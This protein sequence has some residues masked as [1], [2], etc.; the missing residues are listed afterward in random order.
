MTTTVIS[1]GSHIPGLIIGEGEI[2]DVLYGGEADYPTVSSGGTV[3]LGTGAVVSRAT[4]ESGGLVSGPGLAE[5]TVYVYGTLEGATYADTAY[6]LKISSGGLADEVTVDSGSHEIVALGGEV[7]GGV[8]SSGGELL[9][10]DGAPLNG[11][12]T[13]GVLLE[14]ALTLGVATGAITESAVLGGGS[15]LA[16]VKVSS[17]G[18]VEL[19]QV[20]SM[21]VSS[22]GTLTILGGDGI[23]NTTV[24]NGG[25]MKIASGAEAYDPTVSSGGKV[26]LARGAVVSRVTVAS[27]GLM[28]GPGMAEG[29]VFVYGTLEGA[30]FQSDGYSLKVYSGGLAEATTVLSD[31]IVDVL[32]GGAERGAI[33]SSGGE[34]VVSAGGKAAGTR[35]LKG[36]TEKVLGTDSGALVSK[37]GQLVVFAGGAASETRVL[38][39][40]SEQI[41][42]GGK[43][44]GILTL[45]GGTAT[46]SS[47]AV[48]RDA[49]VDFV[50][51]GGVLALAASA[52][53]AGTISGFSDPSQ[54]IDL[55]GFTFSAGETVSWAAAVGDTS[56]TLTV[57]DGGQSLSLKLLGSYVTSNFTLSKDSHG[58]TV[59]SDPPAISQPAHA[60]IQA[61][62]SFPPPIP[63]AEAPTPV[64]VASPPILT[65]AHAT[66]SAGL[67]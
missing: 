16:G 41:L 32:A 44:A 39:G 4:V 25:T 17:G 2:L 26:S 14:G 60:F 7:S 31:G 12:L 61:M 11:G 58:E 42:S 34:V 29:A 22:G 40:G 66:A 37:G 64:S 49:A 51:S 56:G 50:G 53:F 43:L 59:I 19:D 15:G 57:E 23:A 6:N 27:G 55:L 67:L 63:A 20:T 28:S 24:F 36:G 9:L 48:T 35:V 62:A 52:G 1:S 65:F 3:S 8:V 45:S 18:E 5:G 47:G 46:V 38:S 54:K 13:L 33:V 21:Q 10:A 30:T